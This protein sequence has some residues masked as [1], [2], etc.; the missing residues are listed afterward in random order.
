ML[1]DE[2]VSTACAERN[3]GYHR[4]DAVRPYP[5]SRGTKWDCRS[6]NAYI[7][8]LAGAA[9]APFNP[10]FFRAPQSVRQMQP[11]YLRVRRAGAITMQ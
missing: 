6:R 4:F 3:Q 7:L 1:I 8:A 11:A 9:S 10:C 5:D 2:F